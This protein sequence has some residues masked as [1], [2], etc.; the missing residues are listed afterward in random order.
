[1]THGRKYGERDSH[2][3]PLWNGVFEHY[4]RIGDALWEFAWC[5]DR[6]TEER[7]D[8][9]IVLGGS[10]VKLRTIVDALKGSRKETVRRHMDSLEREN[11][12]RRRRT[13]FGHVI[14]VLNSR[15]FGIWKKEKPKNDVSPSLRNLRQRL[16]L[17]KSDNLSGLARWF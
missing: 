13:P 6:I 10:P 11:Y 14:E 8:I 12:I 7:D 2:P 16:T 1:M 5:I 17:T 9:G 3:I 4:D 15:K